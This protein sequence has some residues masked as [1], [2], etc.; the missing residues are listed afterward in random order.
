MPFNTFPK[1]SVLLV[2][3]LSSL[4]TS[5]FSCCVVLALFLERAALILRCSMIMV[6][7]HIYT[8]LI[9]DYMSLRYTVYAVN[10][11]ST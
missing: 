11:K 7:L 6:E 3:K 8:V 1:F 2:V 9:L 10:S 5:G 4:C